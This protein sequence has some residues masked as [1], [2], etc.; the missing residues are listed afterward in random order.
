MATLPYLGLGLSSNLSARD[1]P[2]PYRLL[3][4][5]PGAFD[6]VEYSA[7][8]S[9]E[10]TK[11]QASLFEEMFARRA[12]VPAL[13][14]P[15]HLNLWGP[16]LEPVEDLRALDAH[17]KAVGSPWLGNDV[18]WWHAGGQPFPGYLYLPP[19]MNE[20]GLADATAHALHVQAQVSVPLVL[21]NPAVIALRGGLHVLDFMAALHARTRLPLLLDL[22]HLL[23][24][25]RSAGL[26]E[27]AGLDGFPLEEVVEVHIA[28]GVLT[29][30]G[31][32][33]F[34]VDDHTQPV[35][36]ELFHLLELI[37]PRLT[38]L[39]ALT[40]EGDGH[41][42]AIALPTLR[43][44]RQALPK[45]G[46]EVELPVPPPPSPLT[47]ESRPWELF[48]ERYGAS[49]AKEDEAGTRA[50]L[51][52]RL[53]V[54]AETLDRSF[55]LSRLLILGSREALRGFTASEAF[56][57][58]FE[59]GKPLPAAYLSY[60][61]SSL[62]EGVDPSVAAAVA[63]EQ[64]A[65]GLLAQPPQPGLPEDVR[66]GEFAVDLT[67]LL[68]ATRALRRHLAQRA[69]GSGRLETGGLDALTQVARRAAPERWAVAVIQRGGSLTVQ[70]LAADEVAA[71]RAASVAAQGGEGGGQAADPVRER[72]QA[73]GVLL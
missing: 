49:V 5:H 71:I 46:P 14:H 72:L 45:P 59:D 11:A 4:S 38:G 32:R 34:Y 13:F 43:R 68:F 54:V 40:F 53:A 31:E 30:A 62:R 10:E 56:R 18:G 26:E 47:G 29:P 50:E 52:F 21:E 19:P 12:Q 20:A 35:R 66:V 57:G 27:T 44:L 48:S 67:E 7:P 2:H 16:T 42:D 58:I 25:Q 28:G 61:R 3:D 33:A 41:P 22:G 17:L 15:V 24:Y 8:L 9:L 64:W 37:R 39:R 65:H 23:S 63:F 55:P 70:P 73:A 51:D 1:V 6:F 60:A 69:H 36:E